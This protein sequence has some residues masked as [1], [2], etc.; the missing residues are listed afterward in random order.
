MALSFSPWFILFFVY[1]LGS[2]SSPHHQ[3]HEVQGSDDL[4]KV[5]K[6]SNPM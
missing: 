2:A 1:T 3:F 5:T 4:S 6:G